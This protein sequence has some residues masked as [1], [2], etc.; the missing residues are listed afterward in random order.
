MIVKIVAVTAGIA[1]LIGRYSKTFRVKELSDTFY[2]NKGR[3]ETQISNDA[4][5]QLKNEI[6]SSGAVKYK[7]LENGNVK[8]SIKVI[9]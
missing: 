2:P 7:E 6:A 5:M 3:S 4:V 1:F 8:V 9:V